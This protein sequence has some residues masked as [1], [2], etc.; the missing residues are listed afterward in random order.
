VEL[1]IDV[2]RAAHLQ[3]G[4]RIFAALGQLGAEQ[5]TQLGI[6]GIA[7]DGGAQSRDLWRIHGHRLEK[8]SVSIADEFGVVWAVFRVMQSAIRAW[9]GPGS[10]RQRRT[11]K[12]R[13]AT[14]RGA[15][16]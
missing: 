3:D 1:R 11:L 12:G 2:E 15:S 13:F 8:V 4:F 16:G 9:R 7:R 14:L 6:A 5:I 10:R